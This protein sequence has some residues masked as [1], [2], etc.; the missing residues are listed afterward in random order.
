[1][2]LCIFSGKVI[3]EMTYTVLGGMLNPTYLLTH[4]FLVLNFTFFGLEIVL[5]FTSLVFMEM[6]SLK[7]CVFV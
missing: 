2:C 1:M 6:W 4:S 3:P 5:L 7:K